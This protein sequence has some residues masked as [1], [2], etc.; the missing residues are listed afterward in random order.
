MSYYQKKPK[1]NSLIYSELGKHMNVAYFT[2]L[3][4]TGI[5]QY[6]KELL[7]YLQEHFDIDLFSNKYQLKKYT[8]YDANIYHIGNSKYHKYMI[9]N[10]KQ[11][12]GI[13]VFHDIILYGIYSFSFYRKNPLIDIVKHTNVAVCHNNFAMK[14]LQQFNVPVKK[15]HHSINLPEQVGIKEELS[16]YD[17]VIGSFGNIVPSK[18]L[19]VVIRSFQEF[20]KQY[21]NSAYILVG[22]SIKPPAN[23][24]SENV[25]QKGRVSMQDFYE[26]INSCDL[27][28][29]LRYPSYGET[30]GSLLRIFGLGKPTVISD[31]AQYSEFPDDICI[32]VKVDKNEQENI[33]KAMSYIKE[34]NTL[35]GKRARNY[36]IKNHLWSNSA[37][38]YI[39]ILEEMK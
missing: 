6:N 39:D 19:D 10:L 15:V 16:T 9:K 36:I 4:R 34:N 29:N 28:I 23:I 32:K 14:K 7:P 18:R 1:P 37:K 21:P 22:E 33:T 5:A 24:D 2:P 38:E 11:N 30:S 25:I 26:Y 13:T 20:R 35:I 8:N 31:Y 3:K 27:C 12:P 17:F